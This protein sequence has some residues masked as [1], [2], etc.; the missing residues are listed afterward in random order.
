MYLA[1]DIGG[2]KTLLASFKDDGTL[3]Q[4]VKFATPS[5]Y[6]DFLHELTAQLANLDAKEFLSAAVALPG[7][8]DRTTGTGL[9]FGNL[10]WK[11]VPVKADL[12]KILGLSVAVEN[13]ANLAGLSEALLIK[14]E[15]KKVLYITISTGI[16]TGIIINGIIDPTFA[17]SEPGHMVLEHEGKMQIWEDFASGSAIVRRY[18]KRAADI[19]DEATWRILAHDFSLGIIDL[20]ATIQPEIIII[21]GGVGSHFDRF[22]D[23]LKTEL[24]RYETPLVPIP[25]IREAQRAEEAVVYGC[26]ELARSAHE[27]ATN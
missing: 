17:D 7:K 9:R 27:S 11:N 20:V 23:L 12:E 18:G 8:I 19:T 14:D 10:S 2:T 1:V 3:V 13:D 24:K 26:Y 4:S 22:G 21:G 25:P 6:P 15:F 16:G 5:D